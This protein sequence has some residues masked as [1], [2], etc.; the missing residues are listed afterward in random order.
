M[1]VT[2]GLYVTNI[3]LPP[4]KRRL[5][6]VSITPWISPKNIDLSD[7]IH[8]T[9]TLMTFLFLTADSY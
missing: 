1:L 9:H 6:G 2:F 3:P 5:D 7:Y 4:L 8:V